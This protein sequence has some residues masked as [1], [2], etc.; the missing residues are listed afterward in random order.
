[1]EPCRV[2]DKVDAME[3]LI[4]RFAGEPLRIA[5]PVR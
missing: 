4:A 2:A 3:T 5:D 1:M